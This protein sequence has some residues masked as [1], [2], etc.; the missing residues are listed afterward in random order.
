MIST[1]KT[2]VYI[3]WMPYSFVWLYLIKYVF[4]C[5]I[6]V[7]SNTK[8]FLSVLVVFG[9]HFVFTKTENFKNS[10]ALFRLSQVTC[11]SR[12]LV[13]RFW[14]LV[15]KWKVQS[16]GVHRDFRG[17]ARDS[18]ASE[19]S[20]CEKNLA[21][22]FQ[23]FWLEVFGD[24]KLAIVWR[25]SSVAKIAWFAKRSFFFFFNTNLK[26]SLNFFFSCI[27]WLFIFWSHFQYFN[28]T[29]VN[30]KIFHYFVTIFS[31]FKERYGFCPLL[32][33][34]HSYCLFLMDFVLFMIFVYLLTVFGYLIVWCLHCVFFGGYIL[35]YSILC[36]HWVINVT[37]CHFLVIPT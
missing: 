35:I 33:I 23:N 18:L 20:S 16:Q 26:K 37:H 1:H 8:R 15:R 27:L 31:I 4:T 36:Q 25:L 10:V 7:D 17:S 2:Q 3:Q 21:N 12:V 29:V 5:S 14:R 34:F 6:F 22:F 24:W 9:K 19:T 11:H 13:G 28:T 30:S 32:F